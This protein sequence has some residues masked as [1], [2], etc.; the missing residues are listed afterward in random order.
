MES[1]GTFLRHNEGSEGRAVF[2][3]IDGNA[4]ERGAR[5]ERE[6]TDNA[7]YVKVHLPVPLL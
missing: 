7:T 2:N 1:T 6:D 3:C 4:T 5:K